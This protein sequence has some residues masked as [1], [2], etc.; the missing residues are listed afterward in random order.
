MEDLDLVVALRRQDEGSAKELFN[1]YGQE[2]YSLIYKMTQNNQIAK[3]L[4]IKTFESFSAQKFQLNPTTLPIFSSLVSIARQLVL[5]ARMKDESLMI[6]FD[7]NEK[8]SE[9]INKSYSD[10]INQFYLRGNTLTNIAKQLRVPESTG[11]TRFRL[12]LNALK[13]KFDN[14]SGSFIS[15]ITVTLISSL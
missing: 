3:E 11:R 14:E 7:T 10:I 9:L 2:I 15:L 4:T 12:A 6:S 1:S 8:E 13:K 5:S